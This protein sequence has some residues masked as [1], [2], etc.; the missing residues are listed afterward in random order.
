[1]SLCITGTCP[2]GRD[3]F[4]WLGDGPEGDG[5][6]PWVHAAPPVPGHLEVCDLMPFATAEEAGEAC[7]CSHE[8]RRHP[9]SGP[10]PG[11]PAVPARVMPCLDCACVGFRHRPQDLKRH[12]EDA[13]VPVAEARAALDRLLAAGDAACS[14]GCGYRATVVVPVQGTLL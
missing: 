3:V 7:A 12:R 1:M 8:S 10:V 11:A 5:T 9:P 4:I 2:H 6:Y 14:C 13:P